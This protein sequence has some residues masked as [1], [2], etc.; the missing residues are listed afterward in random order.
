[1]LTPQSAY[2]AIHSHYPPSSPRPRIGITANFGEKGAELAEG[3][4][5]SVVR[6]GGIPVIVPPT[7]DPEVLISILDTIDALILSGGGDINPLILGE[8]PI[9]QLGSINPRR[10]DSELLLTRLA[11]NRQL[12]I[13]GICRGSQVLAAALGGSIYQDIAA[14]HTPQAKTFPSSVPPSPSSLSSPSSPSSPSSASPSLPLSMSPYYGD[15]SPLIKHSQALDRAYPSHTVVIAP[16]TTLHSIFLPHECAERLCRGESPASSIPPTSSPTPTSDSPIILPVNSFHHQAVSTTGSHLRVSATA[17]DGIIEAVESTEHKSIIGVQWHP[18][19]FI[20][21]G[22]ESHLPL[23][24]WLVSEATSYATA[25]RF[26]ATHITIDSH[27]DT[28]MFFDQDIHFDQRDPRILVDLHKMTEGGL[29]ATTMVAYIPQVPLTEASRDEAF[30]LANARLD[31]IEVLATHP[32]VAIVRNATAAENP[33]LTLADLPAIKASGR[34]AILPAIENGFAIGLDLARL[35]HFA[36]RGI[37]YMTLCHNGNNDICGS[38]R[39]RDGEPMMGLTPFGRTV[40]SRMNDLGIAVD[41]S[42]ASEASFYEAME[43]SRTP[44]LCSHSSARALCDHPRNLTDDQLRALARNGG[45]AQAT[46]YGGFLRTDGAAT[47]NDAVEHILHMV[48]IAGIE[49]VGIGTD[50]DG[51]GGVPGL[52]SAAE[53]INLSRRLARH[54]SPADLALLWGGNYLRLLN[55][56]QSSALHSKANH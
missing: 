13:L 19:C 50:F 28:P 24:R 17:P 10:D 3:Y 55:Q 35:E 21:R 31:G 4:Y 18:E 51:D 49:H 41:L 22:D 8:Q 40:I 56:V 53:L 33:P 25:R 12:P 46:F 9:P 54:F 38:A 20:L 2:N 5:E 36:R 23:F 7:A 30:R 43:L 29:D 6:A 44:I 37:H 34:R 47:I 1:M 42:H 27:C 45:V 39:P 26:H 11:A 48:R 15:P 14:Q 52:A 32:S 16:G